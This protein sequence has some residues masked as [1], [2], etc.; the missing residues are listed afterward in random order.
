MKATGVCTNRSCAITSVLLDVNV[1]GPPFALSCGNC[2]QVSR[3]SDSERS[4]E[5]PQEF[6]LQS[7]FGSYAAN[8][9]SK[10]TDCSIPGVKLVA[11][12]NDGFQILPKA[13][14]GLGSSAI[15]SAHSRF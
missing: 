7:R 1:F 11:N 14:I 13:K 4:L 5:Y 3:P 9:K 10:I 8:P 12:C 15:V 2:C 6:E